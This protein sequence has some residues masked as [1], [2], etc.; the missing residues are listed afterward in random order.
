[1][2]VPSLLAVFA[3]PDD[4]SLSAGGV[5]ARHAA[6]GARTAV[7]TTTWAA[8]TSR[9]AELAEALRILSA[10][11]PRMLGY[12]D[13]RVPQ[14]A[15]GRMRFCDA[16]L[17]E[18]VRRLVAHIREFRPDIMITHDAYGGLTGHPDHVHTHRV[19]ML[20]AQAAG[21]GPLYPDA[22][23]PWQPRALYL[24]T[25]PHSAVPGLRGVIGARKAV[26]S[27]PDEQVTATVDVGPWIE[28]KIAAVLAH[29][30]EVKRGALPGVIASL[31]PNARERL[32]ATEWYIR[33][34]PITAASAQTELTA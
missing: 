27:V 16:P 10:G 26:Y 29:R 33:H 34:A 13:A 2:P 21:L 3:H 19:T 12:A 1:M 14:S 31:P 18:T 6:A 30:S 4:E 20:A 7:V 8:D 5:L 28:Q 25:H 23:A 24:A 9:A 32:F 22:G 11:E 17:D 15:P